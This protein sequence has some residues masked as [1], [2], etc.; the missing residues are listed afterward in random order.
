MSTIL[1]G[2]KHPEIAIQ[3][4]NLASIIQD[5]GDL[6][7]AES[8]YRQALNMER[9]MMGPVHPEVANTLNNIAFVQY[10]RGN[11]SGALAT[12]RQSLAV[13]RKLFPGDHPDVA[14][15]M[16]RIGFWLTQAKQYAEAEQNLTQALAMRRRLVGDSHP[17]IASSLF[18]VAFLQVATRRY[19][20]AL[21][22]AQH[23]AEIYTGA[24]PANHWKT[25]AAQVAEG[26]SL[27]GLGRTREAERLLAHSVA[28]LEKDSDAPKVY[29]ALGKRYLEDVRRKAQSNVPPP[30]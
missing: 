15:V 17:D 28:I 5:Q 18:H 22:N 26:A 8:T 30:A 4:N 6:A 23:A 3:L 25:A 27:G 9:E 14:A 21:Q 24:L 11:T 13:Y 1:L 20:E 12:E 7:R 10:D 29:G 19:G 16:N 2:A